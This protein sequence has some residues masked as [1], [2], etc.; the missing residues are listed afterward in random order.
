MI[1]NGDANDNDI[2]TLAD[3]L[4]KTN[5]TDF[6][7][8]EKAQYANWGLREIFKE[9]YKVF[10]GWTFQ[11]SNVSGTDQVMTNLLNDGTQFYAFATVGALA[12]MEYEDEN[13]NKFPLTPITLEEIRAMGYSEDEFM[14]EP[15]TPQYYRPVKNGVKIYPAWYTSKAA[16]TNGLIAKI[17][18]Q[19][20]SAF[21]NS[22][23]SVS[24]GYDSLA[25]HEAVAV[26]MAMKFAQIN[27]LDSFAG[28]FNDWLTALK[29]VKDHYA[30]KYAEVKPRIRKGHGG[31]NYASEFVS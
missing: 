26:F 5:D 25:G 2:C 12:G 4:A 16:V 3:T 28:L 18:S 19:D 10:G 27:T 23:T 6:P 24:P 7:L 29:G 14:D 17:K 15:S 13:G 9:I 30:S 1:F 22:S 21:S 31:N 11:D 20:I 8:K